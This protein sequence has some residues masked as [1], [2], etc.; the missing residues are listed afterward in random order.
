MADVFLRLK[1]E[2]KLPVEIAMVVPTGAFDL[3]LG[4]GVVFTLRGA[5]RQ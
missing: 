5:D 4:M 1:S 2:G 3:C